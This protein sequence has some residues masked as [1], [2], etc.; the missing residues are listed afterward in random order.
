MSLVILV[1]GHERI[2]Y[3]VFSTFTSVSPSHGD[4]CCRYYETR[5]ERCA[6]FSNVSSL[7]VMLICSICKTHRTAQNDNLF[8]LV[9]HCVEYLP[10]VRGSS[11]LRHYAKSR[12]VAGSSPDE[13]DFF[14]ELT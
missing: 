12:K 6:V 8:F 11:W 14:F 13:V 10:G 9:F 3:F 5:I 4:L 2:A 7:S 1:T